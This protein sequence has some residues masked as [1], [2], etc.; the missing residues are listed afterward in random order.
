MMN[1]PQYK[2]D[3]KKS[4]HIPIFLFGTFKE[5]VWGSNLYNITGHKKAYIYGFGLFTM[6]A[7]IGKGYEFPHMV[8]SKKADSIVYGEIAVV[9]KRIARYIKIAKGNNYKFN[10][11][12][13]Y[14]DDKNYTWC[15]ALAMDRMIFNQYK[16]QDRFF[17][18]TE[19]KP[20]EVSQ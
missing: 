12:K 16:F 6:G 11:I 8:K 18:I 20:Y 13:A 9:K 14:F 15:I 3:L 19:W 10:T 1:Y 17:K 5:G 7:I 4:K 2:E